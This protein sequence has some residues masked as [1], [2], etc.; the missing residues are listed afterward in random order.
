MK[1][2]V[3]P[4]RSPRGLDRV[5]RPGVSGVLDGAGEHGLRCVLHVIVHNMTVVKTVNE[6]TDF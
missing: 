2:D 1:S 6:L 4:A 5:A 3:T